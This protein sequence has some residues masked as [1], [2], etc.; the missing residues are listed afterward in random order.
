MRVDGLMI[1]K[2]RSVVILTTER[3]KFITD[4]FNPMY[5]VCGIRSEALSWLLYRCS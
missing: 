3:F 4:Y 1:V 5:M 2:K